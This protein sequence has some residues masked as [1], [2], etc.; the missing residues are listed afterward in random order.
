MSEYPNRATVTVTG[1]SWAEERVV[2]AGYAG[3]VGAGSYA[4]DAMEYTLTLD[5]DFADAG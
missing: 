5:Y 4:A 1:K 3:L 2:E